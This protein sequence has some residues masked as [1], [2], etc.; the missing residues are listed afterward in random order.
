MTKLSDYLY[1]ADSSG[2]NKVDKE[3]VTKTVTH[4]ADYMENETLAGL[5]NDLEA[6]TF[7]A[8][9]NPFNY[10]NHRRLKAMTESKPA[11]LLVLGI[12]KT[13][14]T[15]QEV[16]ARLSAM[17]IN[18]ILLTTSNSG[19]NLKYRLLIPVSEA[20]S[21]DMWKPTQQ[22][23]ARL[24]NLA[25]DDLPY[26]QMQFI[27]ADRKMLHHING[28]SL[29]ITG[30]EVVTGMPTLKV[31][32]PNV[33]EVNSEA[34]ARPAMAERAVATREQK[35]MLRQTKQNTLLITDKSY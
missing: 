31:L 25:I 15:M 5:R 28:K 1:I 35:C 21:A 16:N 34:I 22:A 26:S 19:N 33:K 20:L 32:K 3:I 30:V 8:A 10:T 23:V 14:E 18:H 12:D 9:I 6:N 13:T 27:Y 7:F 11:H 2:D 4:Y 24:L 17:D 29:R